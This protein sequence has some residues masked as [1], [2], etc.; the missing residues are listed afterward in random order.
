MGLISCPEHGD[1]LW[2]LVSPDLLD[3]QVNDGDV[4]LI[5]FTF[6]GAKPALCGCISVIC[7]WTSPPKS[8][9]SLD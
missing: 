5:F 9:K 2:C 3:N 1:Q 6:G 8:K 7:C 4:K